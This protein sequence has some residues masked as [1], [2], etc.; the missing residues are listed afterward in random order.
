MSETD[1][2]MPE[3]ISEDSGTELLSELSN[4]SWDDY[5]DLEVEL[6]SSD[7]EDS[8]DPDETERNRQML[9]QILLEYRNRLINPSNN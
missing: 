8:E 4:E 1:P 6:V 3:L 9:V 7:S 5:Q 2:D